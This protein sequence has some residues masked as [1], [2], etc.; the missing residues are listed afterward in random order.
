MPLVENKTFGEITVGDS[1][2]I[3]R[4]LQAGD[5]RAWPPPLA[6]RA[7]SSAQAKARR[8]LASSLAS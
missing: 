8:L 6:K 7:R 4:T 1:A 2:S 5:V 3:E